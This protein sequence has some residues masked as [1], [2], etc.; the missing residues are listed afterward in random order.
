MTR[1]A[2]APV[3]RAG[4]MLEG[5]MASSK[6]GTGRNTPRTLTV[7]L[8]LWM[9][10]MD[11]GAANCSITVTALDF[12]IYDP[13]AT[14]PLDMNGNVDVRCTGNAGSFILAISQGNAGGFSPRLM[15]SGPFSMQYNLY[16]DPARSLVWGDGTGGTGVN[17]GN[18]PSAGP[19]VN[20]SF[21]VYGR[22]FPNQ[23]VASGLYSDSLVVTAVF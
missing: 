19:P 21:P 2:K 14:A 17:S 7:L 5:D 20:F 10:C 8:A 22:I 18:K 11:A 1:A 23:A 12:G 9:L 4:G 13:G 16:T 15:L 3:T 6:R